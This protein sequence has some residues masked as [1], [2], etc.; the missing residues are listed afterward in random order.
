M[1]L[2]NWLV[3]GLDVKWIPSV[4]P[5]EAYA[6]FIRHK[7]TPDGLPC[8][9]GSGKSI[10]WLV[11]LLS[12]SCYSTHLDHK[13]CDHTTLYAISQRRTG[14]VSVFL[15]RFSGRS[16]AKRSQ[17]CHLSPSPTFR[18]FEAMLRYHLPT[19]FNAWEGHATAQQWYL[20][21]LFIG[22]AD[23]H[24]RTPNFHHHGRTR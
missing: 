18:I 16:K 23:S 24:R 11:K 15:L 5:R 17:P 2:R 13:F 9:A 20:D 22:D 7:S 4:D 12:L 19:L 1:V 8:V 21:E 14:Y 6:P 10:V 3:Q